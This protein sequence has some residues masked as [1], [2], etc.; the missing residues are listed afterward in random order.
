MAKVN[1]CII[2]NNLRFPSG[3]KVEYVISE[4]IIGGILYVARLT[5]LVKSKGSGLF[6]IITSTWCYGSEVMNSDPLILKAIW[7]TKN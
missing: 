3:E 1:S 4:T 6:L 7:D 5:D 2:D